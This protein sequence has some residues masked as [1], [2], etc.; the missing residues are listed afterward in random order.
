MWHASN[1]DAVRI[2][3][4]EMSDVTTKFA[5][6]FAAVLIAVSSLAA[7]VQV[8]HAMAQHDVASPAMGPAMATIIA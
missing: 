5:A 6:A 3:E 7:V 1:L 4:H 8:P 2:G